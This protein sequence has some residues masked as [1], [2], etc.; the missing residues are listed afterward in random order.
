MERVNK[1]IFWTL[2]KRKRERKMPK[3]SL[4]FTAKK[5]KVILILHFLQ[6]EP[7]NMY[8]IKDDF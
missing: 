6:C 4:L 8:R 1:Q 5:N 2:K 7:K 3:M